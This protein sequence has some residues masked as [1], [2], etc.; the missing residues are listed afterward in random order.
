MAY[1][2]G[3]AS[4]TD[5]GVVEIGSNILVDINGIISIP[6]SVATTAN[7]TFN[8]VTVASEINTGNLSVGG[9]LT[10]TGN[11]S[12]PALFDSNLRV[13]TSVTPAAST[14]ISITGLSVGG[15]ASAFTI[16]NTGVIGLVAGTGIS[17]SS[18]TGNVT[19]SSTGTS[20]L[21][22][23]AA[24][25]SYTATATDEYIGVTSNSNLT[26]T[27]PIGIV[28]RTY[29]V[30]DETGNQPKITVSGTG[31]EKIDGSNTKS[32]TLA[33]SSITVVFRAGQWHI[34]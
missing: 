6:Q 20:V 5:Y 17:L 30:K 3:P 14:G 15:T 2:N 33:Y 4:T 34:I 28:G 29:I 26:I 32:I 8:N 31:A 19:V 11:I 22:T 13:V 7:V 12:A 1:L 24:N 10:V 21:N 23:I 16:N 25:V 27:L 9:T 18:A